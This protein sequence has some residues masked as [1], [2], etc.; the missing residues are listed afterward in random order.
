MCA[1][2]QFWKSWF[3]VMDLVITF[4]CVITLLVILIAGCDN[5]S[6]EEE[7]LDTLLLVAR[8]ILQ[9]GR[10]AVV[11]RQCVPCLFFIPRSFFFA[12]MN[13]GP[14]PDSRFSRAR[15]QLIYL[16]LAED[17]TPSILTWKMMKRLMISV[18]RSSVTLWYLTRVMMSRPRREGV[19]PICREQRK[20]Y[21]IE[22]LRMFGLSWVDVRVGNTHVLHSIVL[23]EI[24]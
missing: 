19:C 4:F 6:K 20:L 10:L 2:Q 5:T 7:I 3:N 14:D 17:H 1:M 22:T 18:V 16:R 21:T 9:F 23:C 24:M 8:N 11:M 15:S 12:K 13:D